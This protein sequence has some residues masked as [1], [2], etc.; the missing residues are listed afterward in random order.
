MN[1]AMDLLHCFHNKCN[2]VIFL[3]GGEMC[4]LTLKNYE[5]LKFA[6]KLSFNKAKEKLFN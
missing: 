6:Q 1:L 4:H 5:T 3:G 2:V